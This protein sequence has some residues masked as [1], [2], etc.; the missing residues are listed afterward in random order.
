MYTK[1]SSLL[2][3]LLVCL[4]LFFS[5]LA[6]PALAEDVS[7]ENLFNKRDKDFREGYNF[8]QSTEQITTEPDSFITGYIAVNAG[9][10]AE[11]FSLPVPDHILA[12]PECLFDRQMQ[13]YNIFYHDSLLS[14]LP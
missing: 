2:C 9:D 11:P 7:D 14:S 8:I 12:D 6:V 5:V 13:T 10:N 4:T 3:R 1:H